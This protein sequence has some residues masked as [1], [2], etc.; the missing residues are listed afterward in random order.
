MMNKTLQ[1]R[2]DIN[3][4]NSNDSVEHLVIDMDSE[5]NCEIV[6]EIIDK[7]NPHLF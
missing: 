1:L 3:N 6:I 7:S 4:V 2:L 5:S